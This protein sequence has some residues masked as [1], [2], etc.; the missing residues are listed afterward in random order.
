MHF[1]QLAVI[2]RQ[3]QAAGSSILVTYHT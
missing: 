3:Y 2:S 1:S